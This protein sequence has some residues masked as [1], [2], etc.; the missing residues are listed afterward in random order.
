MYVLLNIDLGVKQQGAVRANSPTSLVW[1]FLTSGHQSCSRFWCLQQSSSAIDGDDMGG[2]ITDDD[3][4]SR[5]RMG[6]GLGVESSSSSALALASVSSS[7]SGSGHND[8][9]RNAEEYKSQQY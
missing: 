1:G 4:G 5:T 8:C 9:L 2:D 3:T 7:I 6:G